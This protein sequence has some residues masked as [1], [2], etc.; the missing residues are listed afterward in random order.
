KDFKVIDDFKE[1]KKVTSSID[2]IYAMQNALFHK[3]KSENYSLEEL[4][5]FLLYDLMIN[6][7]LS[8]VNVREKFNANE[9]IVV[10][11]NKEFLLSFE[12]IIKNKEQLLKEDLI[13]MGKNEVNYKD[14]LIVF[15]DELCLKVFN[16]C[17]I[18]AQM[19]CFDM[20]VIKKKQFKYNAF[21]KGFYPEVA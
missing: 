16:Y 10:H 20:E 12:E 21:K 13:Q 19:R 2:I 9:A 18:T 8:F 11:A 3:I 17:D 4:F 7:D 15:S 14:N 1:S 6:H 5:T